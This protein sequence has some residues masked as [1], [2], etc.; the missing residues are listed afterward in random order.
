[1]HTETERC[2]PH[3]EDT[4]AQATPSASSQAGKFL[5]QTDCPEG[6]YQGETG[7]GQCC[8]GAGLQKEEHRVG[9]HR[10]EEES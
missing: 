7:E 8:E 1:M 5:F 9:G 3:P 2:D 6:K 10:E 4:G